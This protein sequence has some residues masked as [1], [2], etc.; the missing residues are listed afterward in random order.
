M[1]FVKAYR[2][3]RNPWPETEACTLC[4]VRRHTD[5][6]GGP[7]LSPSAGPSQHSSRSDSKSQLGHS[8][9]CGC[10]GPAGLRLPGQFALGLKGSRV[11]C[12][13]LNTEL[14]AH[15]SAKGQNVVRALG[16]QRQFA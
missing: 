3:D 5:V 4:H 12:P 7:S 11:T 9:H 15:L 14:T 8:G 13:P 2:A 6:S 16:L 1:C 10:L